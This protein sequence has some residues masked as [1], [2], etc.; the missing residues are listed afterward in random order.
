[1]DEPGEDGLWEADPNQLYVNDGDGTFT[2]DT[3]AFDDRSGRG[4][5]YMAGFLDADV[6]GDLDVYVV[7]DKGFDS[8]PNALLLND[9]SGRFTFDNG[10]SYT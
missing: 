1:L 9:G 5:S 4:F 6:D 10:A 2:E 7:N 8:H 3:D